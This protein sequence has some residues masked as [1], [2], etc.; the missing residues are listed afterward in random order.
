MRIGA[1]LIV[2]AALAAVAASTGGAA[3]SSHRAARAV[4][5]PATSAVWSPNG[6][7]IGITYAGTTSSSGQRLKSRIVRTSSR[8]GGA[9]RTVLTG[10]HIDSMSWA[11]GGR[12]LFSKDQFLYSVSM[13]GGKPKRLAVPDCQDSSSCGIDWYTLSPD[14]KIAAV[15]ACNCSDRRFDGFLELVRL[16][17]GGGSAEFAPGPIGGDAFR[18]FSPDSKQLVFSDASGLMA[19]PLDGGNPVPLAQSGIPG[20]SLVPSDAQQVE[21]SPDG[22]WVAYVEYDSTNVHKLEV[23]PTSG[24]GGPGTVATCDADC[25]PLFSWSPTSKLL[26]YDPNSLTGSQL[27]TVRPDGT[28]RTDLLKGRHLLYAGGTPRWSPDGSR[29]LFVAGAT[30]FLNHVWTVRANGRDLI[31]RG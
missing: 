5:Q 19:L 22:S 27:M 28:H 14:R 30:P 1:V 25:D 11:A 13:H 29:L 8:P 2:A 24:A 10:K 20:A 9:S 17:P 15:G 21:W 3:A 16:S 23:V 7:Q 12:I 31:R 4:Q 6:K 26:A 18:G